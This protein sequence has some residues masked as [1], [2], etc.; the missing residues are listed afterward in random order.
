MPVGQGTVRDVIIPMKL[1]KEGINGVSALLPV[2][3]NG[4][5]TKLLVDTGA[6]VTI[7]SSELFN[8]IP[9]NVKPQLTECTSVKLEAADG[10]CIAVAGTATVDITIGTANFA[11]KVYVAPI[12][13][14][15]LL[16]Y[17]FLY[18][19]DCAFEARRGLRINDHWVTCDVIKG[20]PRVARVSLTRETMVPALSECIVEGTADFEGFGT[21]DGLVEPDTC[22]SATAQRDNESN[23]DLIIGNS[24]IDTQRNDIGVPVRIMNTTDEDMHLFKGTSLG[25]VSEVDAVTYQIADHEHDLPESSEHDIVPTC[26]VGLGDPDTCMTSDNNETTKVEENMVS[27][28]CDTHAWCEGLRDLYDRSSKGLDQDQC[29]RLAEL[30]NRHSICFATSPTDLGRTSVLQHSIDTG[31]AQ[32][33]RTPPRRPPMAFKGEEEKIIQQQLDAGVIKASTSPWSSALVYVRKKCGGVRAC[34]D[35]RRLNDL[36]KKDAYPLP[37]INE[38]LDCLGDAKLFS[39]LDLQSGYWQIGVKEQDRCKTAFATHHGL[40]EYITMPFGLCG[41]PSTFQ[42][43]MEL[44]FRKL[45]WKTMLIYMDDLIIFSS[46]FSHHLERLDDVFGRLGKAG[47]KLKPSKCHLLRT[48]VSFLGHVITQ[49]GVKT[50]PK[51]VEVVRTWPV[52]VN[53]T[54][55]RS[56]LGLTSYY[57]RFIVGYSR[58]AHPLNRL[59]EAGQEFEWTN[60]CQ[61]AFELLKGV[62]TSDTVMAYPNDQ[63]LFILD[64]DA[65][66][67]SIGATISQMQW[68]D[69]AQEKVERPIAYAS[70]TLTKTQRRYCVTRRELLAVVVYVWY[71]RHYLMGRK[72]IIR[73]DHSA[74]RWIMSFK[75][76]ENQLARWLEILSQ[77]NFSIIHRSGKKHLNADSL[78]RLPCEPDDCECFDGQ[79]ILEDLPCKGC[80]KCQ[81]KHQLWSDFFEVDDVIPM[82]ARCVNYEPVEK[83]TQCKGSIDKQC[84]VTLSTKPVKS[85][86]DTD[87]NIDDTSTAK[88]STW[89][90]GYSYKDLR[91]LQMKDT[92][93]EPILNWQNQSRKRPKREEVHSR[94]PATRHMW[95]LWDQLVMIH[96]VLFKKHVKADKTQQ[97][98]LLV[99]PKSLQSKVIHASHNPVTAGHQGIKKTRSRLKRSFYWHKLDETVYTY[100]RK[101]AT[102]GA[103]KHP[104]RKPKAGMKEF[105]VGAPMDRVCVDVCGPFPMSYKENKYIL[106]VGDCFTRWIEAYAMPDQTAKTI[107]EQLATRFFPRFGFPLEIHTDQGRSF[108]SDLFQELCR[109]LEIH[110]SRT[111]PY[112]PRSNGMIERFNKSLLNMIAV[113]IESDQ[114]EW[115]INLPLLTSA[116][117]SCTHEATGFSPNMLMLGRESNTPVDIMFGPI[118]TDPEQQEPANKGEYVAEYVDRMHRV[119]QLVR[120]NLD[121]AGERRKRDHDARMSQNNYEVGNLVYYLDST[122]QKGKSPKLKAHRWVGP[123]VVTT[124]YSDVLFEICAKQKGRRRVLHHNRLKPYLSDEM[125]EWIAKLRDDIKRGKPNSSQRESQL[126]ELAT[127]SAG[128]SS[129]VTKRAVS[130]GNAGQSKN[131]TKRAVSTDTGIITNG[132]MEPS[133]DVNVRKSSRAR[134]PPQRYGVAELSKGD[135]TM[136]K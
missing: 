41:A 60:E 48:E 134:R 109:I 4:T 46:T 72:F 110:K 125:P 91:E 76:P 22:Y 37:K 117:R 6:A 16:G 57:R 85:V 103:R 100:V 39:T 124:C 69:V 104:N 115:D 65:S 66:N 33:V 32:P 81:K 136:S 128:Q 21:R 121:K 45:Q 58:I 8:R 82:G 89:I 30:L 129:N 83:I 25:Y 40:Y 88:D 84:N 77:F 131:V 79:T 106:V 52:P 23:A 74:L 123:C 68:S 130:S 133:E 3:I 112:N 122:R 96:G 107:A 24:L 13:D 49:D 34:V 10:N 94:S 93:I 61:S 14:D 27:S 108:E 9:D 56:F 114:R 29:S 73:T 15:G 64:T 63:D 90:D 35:Y 55:V 99:V 38:C 53:L 26:N 101:C 7:I 47:L 51:K 71:F 97:K 75:E 135:D 28:A 1:Q 95:L 59:L 120:E 62:L 78:S 18:N 87:E 43:C 102:C 70:R 116:Y 50:D 92:D 105:R 132:Q 54:D 111:S 127:S 17:D 19:Y 118:I 119:H 11:W 86:A 67:T 44:I 5:E 80:D 20:P 98:L 42:R 36:T 2:T 12:K 113:Y 126:V 31:N